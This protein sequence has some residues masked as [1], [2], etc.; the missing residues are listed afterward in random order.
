MLRLT[1]GLTVNRSQ[2]A[3]DFDEF[4]FAKFSTKK[5][6]NKRKDSNRRLL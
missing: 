2:L 3:L 4:Y 5:T 6:V 1:M